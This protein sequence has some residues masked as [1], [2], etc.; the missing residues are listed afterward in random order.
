MKQYVFS[1]F[2]LLSYILAPI[3]YSWTFNC[4]ILIAFA[5]NFIIVA[6]RPNYHLLSYTTLFFV[7]FFFINFVYPIFIY[8]YDPTFILQ[9]RYSFSPDYINRGTALCF[10][11]F[12]FF[13]SGYVTKGRGHINGKYRYTLKAGTYRLFVVLSYLILVYNLYLIIPQLGLIYGEA[14]VPFQTGSLFVMIECTLSLI[15]CHINREKIKDNLKEYVH[16]LWPHLLASI[17]FCVASLM[18]GSREYVLVLALLYLFLYTKYVRPMA[19]YK[20]CIILIVGM[21]GLYYISQIRNMT[22][23]KAL[24]EEN[25]LFANKPW[26]SNKVSGVWNLASDLIINNRNV[27]VGMQYVD[28]PRHGYTLGMNYIPNIFSPVPF[29]PSLASWVLFNKPAVECTSQ[30]I[31]TNYT[32]DD[33][34]HKEL[35]YELGSNCVIDIY[36]GF[37]AIGVILIFAFLGYFIKVLELSENDLPKMCI[38]LI[39]FTTVVFFCRSSFFGPLRNVVWSYAICLIMLRRYRLS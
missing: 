38:Y 31:L 32:R 21:T 36:M 6:K 35:D 7:V 12:S 17:T 27:Y 34:G 23:D 26:Q 14:S 29:L 24:T 15:K 2:A 28:D 13:L 19:F 16:S 22:S 11:A 5:L 25:D 9:F 3:E 8:P 33:L 18:L 1:L 30:Q 20:L 37:G 4:V 39:L 10:C